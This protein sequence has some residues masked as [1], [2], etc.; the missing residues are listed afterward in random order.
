MRPTLDLE[1]ALRACDNTRMGMAGEGWG[2][3]DSAAASRVSSEGVSIQT[4]DP[5]LPI[6]LRSLYVGPGGDAGIRNRTS[7]N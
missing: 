5:T 3:G 2:G 7:S 6:D 1:K 4:S